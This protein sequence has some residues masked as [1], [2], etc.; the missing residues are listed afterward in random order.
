MNKYIHAFIALLIA[1]PALLPAF[2][3]VKGGVSIIGEEV[4][5]PM[6]S[7]GQRYDFSLLALDFSWSLAASKKHQTAFYTSP[8]AALLI[9]LNP[10]HKNRLYAGAGGSWGYI[11]EREKRTGYS[12]LVADACV[13]IEFQEVG[14]FRSFIEASQS[15]PCKRFSN[16][17]GHI[18]HRASTS[19]TLGIG[20]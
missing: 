6:G 3:Y 11:V 7:M 1:I 19:I 14:C 16:H 20:I 8:R 15:F 17:I 5:A 2:S 4:T 9:Y 18:G 10:M 13:G 12:G